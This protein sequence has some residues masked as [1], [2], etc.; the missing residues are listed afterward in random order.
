MGISHPLPSPGWNSPIPKTGWDR[1]EDIWILGNGNLLSSSHPA[2]IP[3][4]FRPIKSWRPVGGDKNPSG[5]PNPHLTVSLPQTRG[6][7]VPDDYV[8]FRRRRRPKQVTGR[9]GQPTTQ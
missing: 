4:H 8:S 9:S 7:L 3:S 2:I 5:I 1:D 6:V